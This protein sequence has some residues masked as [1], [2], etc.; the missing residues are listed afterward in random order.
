MRI[1]RATRQGDVG[2]V[3]A[4]RAPPDASLPTQPDEGRDPALGE[5]V[6]AADRSR[7]QTGGESRLLAAVAPDRHCDLRRV[8]AAAPRMQSSRQPGRRDRVRGVA[9]VW[10]QAGGRL[11]SRLRQRDAAGSHRCS[12]VCPGGSCVG[13]VAC[14]QRSAV[15]LSK[16]CVAG[17]SPVLRLAKQHCFFLNA[18]SELHLS[19]IIA[20]VD[21][22]SRARDETTGPR[23]IRESRTRGSGAQQRSHCQGAALSVC[24]LSVGPRHCGRW[25]VRRMWPRDPSPRRNAQRTSR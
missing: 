25:I 23:P 18:N 6:A 7:Q 11:L 19:R 14:S 9:L 4:P 2:T 3:D 13:A 20:G 1:P 24:F 5:G 17:G 15:S 12:G 16:Q 22:A 10:C 21:A 8:Q